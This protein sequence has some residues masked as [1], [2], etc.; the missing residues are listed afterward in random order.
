MVVLHITSRHA[1][2]V[3][4]FFEINP[5]VDLRCSCISFKNTGTLVRGDDA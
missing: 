3:P 2:E 5:Q 4:V 1:L